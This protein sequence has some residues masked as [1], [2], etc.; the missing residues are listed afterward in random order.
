MI[1]FNNVS[2]YYGTNRVVDYLSLTIRHGELTVLLGPSGSGKSTTLKLINRLLEHDAGDIEI[3]GKKI[4]SFNT[5]NLQRR[6]GYVIQSIGLFPHWTV[7]QNIATV[8]KLLKWPRARIQ[9]RVTELMTLLYLE[10]AQLHCRYPHQLSGGQQ[11]R[12]GIARALAAY[13]DLLL[14][15]EPFSALDSATRTALQHEIA[16]IQK[17][18]G[19]T[20]VLVTHDIDEAFRL[21]DNIILMDKGKLM[22]Q[23]KPQELLTN[24]ASSFVR[25][26]FPCSDRGITLLG[27]L[28]AKDYMRKQET[29]AGEPIA[30]NTSLRDALSLFIL[31]QTDRLPVADE[32][33]K[34]VGVLHFADLI[35]Q[36]Q[37]HDSAKKTD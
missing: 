10:P 31:R 32:H 6:M 28:R 13:P 12:V 5:Q 19:Q 15:D 4:Q 29:L 14:M 7:E 36:K 34:I 11:Q 35:L 33:K 17:M 25:D 18:S 24:P 2:K 37:L 26:F 3:Y 8:P 22:Q 20:M 9:Q 21:A 23:G 30:G 16:R 1:Q 27:L